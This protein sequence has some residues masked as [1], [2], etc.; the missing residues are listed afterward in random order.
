MG[1]SRMVMKTVTSKHTY[2]TSVVMQ[3]GLLNLEI[4]PNGLS[5]K[6]AARLRTSCEVM[7]VSGQTAIEYVAPADTLHQCDICEKRVS[8]GEALSVS[9]YR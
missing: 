7:P 9:F 8:P 2:D 5:I 6:S 4:G 3:R 1:T